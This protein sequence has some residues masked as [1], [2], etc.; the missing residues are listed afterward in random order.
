M[1]EVLYSAFPSPRAPRAPRVPH[2]P[3]ALGVVRGEGGRP[4]RFGDMLSPNFYSKCTVTRGIPCVT[5]HLIQFNACSPRNGPQLERGRS[6]TI[7][8][9]SVC[10]SLHPN[11][12]KSPTV[13]SRLLSNLH[14]SCLKI[15]SC[16][17][18]SSHKLWKICKLEFSITSNL[19]KSLSQPP[20]EQKSGIGKS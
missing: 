20:K 5:A 17:S 15:L 7:S 8:R 19:P 13:C 2:A 4:S 6:G 1:L 14:V 9:T 3:H 18:L 11:A 12:A 16:G 10:S